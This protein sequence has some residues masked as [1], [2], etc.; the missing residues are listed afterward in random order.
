MSSNVKT[1]NKS[2]ILRLLIVV[3]C[4]Y[5]FFTLGQQFNELGAKKTELA[6]YQTA[7]SETLSRTDEKKNT[8]EN[9]T[10]EELMEDAARAHGYVYPNEQVFVDISGN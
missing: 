4:A 5:V 1:K 3:F 6:G 2:I 7:I 9:S 8:L 10:E